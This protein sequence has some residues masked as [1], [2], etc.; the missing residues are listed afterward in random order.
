MP[1]YTPIVCF[2]DWPTLPV[3]DTL[4]AIHRKAQLL[5]DRFVELF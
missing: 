3:S 1:G 4:R 5:I 2:A